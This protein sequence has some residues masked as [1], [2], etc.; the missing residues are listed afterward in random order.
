MHVRFSRLPEILMTNIE[1]RRSIRVP[2]FREEAAVVVAEGREQPV[3]IVDLSKLGALVNVVDRP[4]L[5]GC[6]FDIDQRLELSMQHK[7]SVFHVTARVTRAGPL[8]IALEFIEDKEDVRLK[9]EDKL[10]VLVK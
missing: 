2:A 1:R 6:N 4:A 9:L 8:F 3:T 10:S 7:N 5:G